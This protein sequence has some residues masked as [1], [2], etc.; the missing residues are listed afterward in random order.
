MF[1]SGNTDNAN[2]C[3]VTYGQLWNVDWPVLKIA[4]TAS[5]QRNSTSISL[6]WEQDSSASA[7][8]LASDLLAGAYIQISGFYF[9]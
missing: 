7:S 9:V 8:W 6:T 1:P 2:V 5:I 3:S 4:G